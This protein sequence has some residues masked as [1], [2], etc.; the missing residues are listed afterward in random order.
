M[1][2]IF[3]IAF[4]ET[5]GCKLDGT[6][7]DCGFAK[8]YLKCRIAGV[9]FIDDFLNHLES[10]SELK[11]DNDN[12]LPSI[13]DFESLAVHEEIQEI[14]DTCYH[15][16]MVY[17]K[18]GDH[19]NMQ[20]DE[21]IANKLLKFCKLLPCWSAVMTPIFKYGNIT[22]SSASSESL[23]K[24]LKHVVL[25]HKTLPIRIDDF[26]KVHVDSIIGTNNII[27]SKMNTN[28]GDIE[29]SQN[30][31]SKLIEINT[32]NNNIQDQP[33]SPEKE[34]ESVAIENWKGLGEDE[35]K[36]KKKGNY[37]EKDQTIFYYNENSKTKSITI[38]LLRNGNCSDLL[39]VLLDG[40]YYTFSN[41]CP[42]DSIFQLLCTTYADDHLYASFIDSKIEED[43]FFKSISR[44]LRDGINVQ[45][46]KRRAK[47]LKC[48]YENET[49]GLTN[50]F[51]N[52]NC[53]ST[54]NFIIMKLFQNWP[55]YEQTTSC[56][57][58][59]T[60]NTRYSSTLMTN[61][62]TNTLDFLEDVVNQLLE[63]QQLDCTNCNL[64]TSTKQIILKQPFNN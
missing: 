1:K 44:A 37:L 32:H 39:P 40:I 42:F 2:Y 6:L 13:N 58:C 49:K 9:T 52:I 46:Y 33:Q 45:T 47:I 50:N 56:S 29:Q 25:Q 5:D 28:Y 54:S 18:I 57:N 20:F 16:S 30:D 61:L 31:T 23:F 35:K 53:A 10:T 17:G 22:E 51:M 34:F 63:P 43:L 27:K 26:I 60:T 14:H 21:N 19:D 15:E 7:T 38:G 11:E 62:P 8:Q 12:S 4:S 48:S 24:D 64:N 3:T 59:S 41:I 55:S 36:K